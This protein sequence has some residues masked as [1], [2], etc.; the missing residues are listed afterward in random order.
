LHD[1]RLRPVESPNELRA[2]HQQRRDKTGPPSMGL[3]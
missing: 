2:E 1:T 3:A